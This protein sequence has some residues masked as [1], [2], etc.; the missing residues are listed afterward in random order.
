MPGVPKMIQ[1]NRHLRKNGP[2]TRLMTLSMIVW[3]SGPNDLDFASFSALSI[4]IS[5][6][7]FSRCHYLINIVMYLV[8][9]PATI[10]RIIAESRDK[11][12]ELNGHSA[13][14]FM[15]R[16]ITSIIS[17]CSRSSV[18]IF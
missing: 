12:L 5:L 10:V 18:L 16:S 14:E 3:F 1:K 4:K 6:S 11:V 13:M 8:S 2:G 9:I 17:M 15:C 7:C